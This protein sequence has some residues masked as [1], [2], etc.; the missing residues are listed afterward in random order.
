MHK[1]MAILTLPLLLLAF[2][3][4]HAQSVIILGG[5]SFAR[6][7][8]TAS[9]LAVQLNSASETDIDNCNKAIQHGAL[10]KRD[11][12]ATLVNRGILFAAM[13]EY[14]RAGKD[15]QSA[16]NLDPKSG[17]AFLNLGNLYFINNAFTL[18]IN[19]YDKA[20]SLELSKGHIAYYNRG[21]AWEN[22][23]DTDKAEND[24]RQAIKLLPEWTTPQLRLKRMLESA[25]KH[26]NNG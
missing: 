19:Q 9:N 10:K 17:E 3:P 18:A 26:V 5:D 20:I 7:C 23:G 2:T 16:I 12:I 1:F 8:F 13:E 22:L 24:Y 11:L 6:E 21:M 25:K 14:Q 15:Y 4:A